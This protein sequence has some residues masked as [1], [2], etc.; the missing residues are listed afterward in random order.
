MTTKSLPGQN[1]MNRARHVQTAHHKG[2]GTRV[3]VWGVPFAVQERKGDPRDQGSG[4]FGIRVQAS[5]SGFGFRVGFRFG[6]RVGVRCRVSGSGFGFRDQ[7]SAYRSR[8]KNARA[9]HA[10][11]CARAVS[12]SSSSTYFASC[13]EESVFFSCEILIIH[14]LRLLPGGKRSFS[15]EILTP[16]GRLTSAHN[17]PP[18]RRKVFFSCEY[19]QHT[20]LFFG[21]GVFWV[22]V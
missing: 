10:S 19:L 11:R 6:F 1:F 8:C 12:K 13:P 3:R 2:F 18:I 9:I 20:A 15:C 7:G 16:D 17:A 5:G 4:F 21:F 14:T 22:V